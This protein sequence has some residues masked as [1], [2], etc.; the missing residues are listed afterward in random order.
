MSS[1][2]KPSGIKPSNIE[3]PKPV[4]PTKL[5]KG[6][7]VS[8]LSPF[9]TDRATQCLLAE[10]KG[11]TAYPLR[12]APNNI[13][14]REMRALE[15]PASPEGS[16]RSG[17]LTPLSETVFPSS[18]TMIPYS[19]WSKFGP[20]LFKPYIVPTHVP[21][22]ANSS[23]SSSC[24]SGPPRITGPNPRPGPHTNP[25]EGSYP[26]GGHSSSSQSS[27]RGLGRHG[28]S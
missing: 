1:P 20:Q 10:A 7:I 26:H 27:T 4:D 17:P 13:I 21:M 25:L 12:H 18:M 16:T 23:N 19:E 28:C 22:T 14:E 8:P 2:R 9:F 11:T 15:P 5:P 6:A 3:L 24:S